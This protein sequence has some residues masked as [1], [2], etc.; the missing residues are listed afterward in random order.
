MMPYD[1]KASHQKD[2]LTN[3][4]LGFGLDLSFI[5]LDLA[6]YGVELGEY[7]G[8]KEDR[9]YLVQL[10]MELGFDPSFNF[11]GGA[12]KAGGRPSSHIKQRR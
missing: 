3:H 6:T 4:P 8:Q 10:T 5:Q 11:L 9:R 7:P 1:Q 2:L 12:N